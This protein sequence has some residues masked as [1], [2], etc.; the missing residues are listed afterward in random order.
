[1]GSG[2]GI[3]VF[4]ATLLPADE[5]DKTQGRMKEPMDDK[6]QDGRGKTA[7]FVRWEDHSLCSLGRNDQK[8]DGRW[9]KRINIIIKK[10]G[11]PRF[12]ARKIASLG[13]RK[14][15]KIE[16]LMLYLIG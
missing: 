1:M 7:H 13:R 14:R 16:G 11:R 5:R 12:C 6:E 10:E 4:L 9:K 3:L 8:E 2:L 15:V